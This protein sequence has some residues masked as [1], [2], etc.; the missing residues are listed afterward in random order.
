MDIHG[1]FIGT[2]L[3]PISDVGLSKQLL[4]LRFPSCH[5]LIAGCFFFVFAGCLAY[6]IPM[7][8]PAVDMGVCALSFAYAQVSAFFVVSGWVPPCS[9][10]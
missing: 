3:Q 9:P 7:W 6:E 4:L 2:L 8:N 1:T 5:L 10:A